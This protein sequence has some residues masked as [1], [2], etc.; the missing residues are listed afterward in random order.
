MLCARH[1]TRGRGLRTVPI[2]QIDLQPLNDDQR[3]ELRTRVV[4]AVSNA[5]GTRY[6]DVSVVIRESEP[7]NLVEAGGSGPYDRWEPVAGSHR[8]MATEA[9]GEEHGCR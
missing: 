1:A 8:L 9:R 5:I 2:V 7:E 6:Q 4:A 3:A